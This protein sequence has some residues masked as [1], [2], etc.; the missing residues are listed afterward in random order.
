M[1]EPVILLGL[2]IYLIL[3]YL[4][5]KTKSNNLFALCG[6]FFLLPMTQYN[7]IIIV[8]LC[9]IGAFFHFILGFFAS[10]ED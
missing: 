7:N 4:S 3:L 5:L 8:L 2:I 9:A 10:K 1:L 6:V